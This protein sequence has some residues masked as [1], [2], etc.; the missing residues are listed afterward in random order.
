MVALLLQ[1]L[2]RG[3]R[4]EACKGWTVG[5]HVSNG[6]SSGWRFSWD[7]KEFQSRSLEGKGVAS[8]GTEASGW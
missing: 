4:P 7:M 3:G 2:G 8:T 1:W 6:S 5:M